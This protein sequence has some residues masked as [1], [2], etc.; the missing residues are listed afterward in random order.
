MLEKA[1]ADKKVTI[2]NARRDSISKIQAAEIQMRE[3][4]EAAISKEKE[5]L[6]GERDKLLSVG[7][8]EAEELERSTD[9]K[10]P[11]VKDFLNK[12]FER[13]LNVAS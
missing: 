10:M 6:G 1:D 13:T 4:S 5:K 12:E 2:A 9:S 11:Q 7:K 3:A 8:A